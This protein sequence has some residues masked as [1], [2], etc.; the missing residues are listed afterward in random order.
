M[1]NSINVEHG[2]SPNEIDYGNG[3]QLLRLVDLKYAKVINI[4]SVKSFLAGSRHKRAIATE[5]VR[6]TIVRYSK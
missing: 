2:Y 3:R 6:E 4:P 5:V 1:N